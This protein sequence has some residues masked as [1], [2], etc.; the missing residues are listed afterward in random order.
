MECHRCGAEVRP[1]QRF[2]DQCGTSLRGVTD[3]TEEMPRPALYDFAADPDDAMQHAD[4]GATTDV[5]TFAPPDATTV[6]PRPTTDTAPAARTA[7]RT[8]EL[9]LI[10]LDADDDGRVHRRRFGVGPLLVLALL[11]ALGAVV[12]AVA[13]T[14]TIETDAVAATFDEGSWSLTDL[15]SD[16][17][18]ALLVTAAA[19]AVGAVAHG[20]RQWWG[21]GLA[22]GAGLALAGMAGLVVGLA[23]QPIQLAQRATS[24]TGAP[25]FTVTITRDVGYVVVVLAG[26]VGVIVFL[27]SL[28]RAG[29]DPI[30]GLNPWIAALGAVAALVAAA[31]PLV[32]EGGA[33][34]SSNWTSGSWYVGDV[35]I[36][37]PTAF[38]AGRLLQAALL[39]GTGVLGFLLVRRYGLGLVVGGASAV[40]W[41]SVSTM[42]ELGDAPVG[43]AYGNP[44]S[45]EMDL[46]SVTIVGMV[47][48]VGLAIVAII[49]AIDESLRDR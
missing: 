47:A 34:V 27:L 39:A 18:V 2:C 40:T 3:A 22:G 35:P 6:S 24:A 20:F 25:A 48:L 29:R 13:T 23:E 8:I 44:G 36:D 12:A 19:L 10:V 42:F 17:P 4:A 26:A 21:A 31:G 38:F 41:L 45:V 1:T 11:G 33:S 30:G 16:L 14:V 46:H 9:P 5:L 49:A 7:D 28:R 15:G 37:Q 43:P 32:P